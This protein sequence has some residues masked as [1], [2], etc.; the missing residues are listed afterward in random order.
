MALYCIGVMCSKPGGGT[1]QY[2]RTFFFFSWRGERLGK[3][4]GKVGQGNL[5]LTNR[6]YKTLPGAPPSPPHPPTQAPLSP[7]GRA[8]PG[9]REGHWQ[10]RLFPSA[11]AR[12][13]IQG[14]QDAQ[15]RKKGVDMG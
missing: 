9:P 14:R 15:V 4:E 11:R 1:S 13:G 5:S 12:V 2:L 7:R 8:G 6:V 3:G 10:T